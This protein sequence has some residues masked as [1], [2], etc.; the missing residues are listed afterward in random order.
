MG[1]SLVE[2]YALPP[3]EIEVRSFSIIEPLL[4]PLDLP[5][6]AR[7]VLLRMV[8]TAGDPA[9]AGEVRMHRQAVAAGVAALRRGA[10]IFT[11]VKMVAAGVDA[12]RA[13]RLGCDVRCFIDE[14]VVAERSRA[15]GTTR[16]VAAMRRLGPE[17]AGAL[18]A[19]GNAPTALLA[20]LDLIDAGMAPP[21]LIV[22]TPVGF[23][24]A[25]ESK[26]ELVRRA[27][28]HI[29]VLG[30][31]GGSPVAAAAVNALLRLA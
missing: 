27:V 14:S 8:H 17:M 26:E 30:T 2:R 16:A 9:I 1:I 25:A 23:V 24:S 11:D 13:A 21:A 10:T 15:Q 4:P 12:V 18:V 6:E 29:T 31:R 28:P 5:T 22:G 19:I 7:P 20:L 3:E